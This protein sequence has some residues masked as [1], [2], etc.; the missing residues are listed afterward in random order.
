MVR[1]LAEPPVSGIDVAFFVQGV[2]HS[3]AQFQIVKRRIRHVEYESAQSS[4]FG[5]DKSDLGNFPIA[6]FFDEG[7]GRPLDDVQITGPQR[8]ETHL[9]VLH[10]FEHQL[11]EVR[12]ALLPVVFVARKN[13]FSCSLV[14]LEFKRSSA[15]R[16]SRGLPLT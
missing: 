10:R 6:D 16:G 1:R 7:V 3:L 4:I 13:H 5:F 15:G 11:V 12:K 2:E 9:L 14:F 8:G